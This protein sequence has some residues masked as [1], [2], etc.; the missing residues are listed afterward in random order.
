MRMDFD[1]QGRES[2]HLAVQK[3]NKSEL[4]SVIFVQGWFSVQ[5]LL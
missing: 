2:E 3:R 4:S 1:F 5:H